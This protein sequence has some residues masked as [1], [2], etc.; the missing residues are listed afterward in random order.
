MYVDRQSTAFAA[1]PGSQASG[2]GFCFLDYTPSGVEELLSSN[3]WPSATIRA[4][5]ER[6]S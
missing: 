5:E 2:D 6:R 3:R 1:R 4:F